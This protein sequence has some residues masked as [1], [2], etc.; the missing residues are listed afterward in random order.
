MLLHLDITSDA[1]EDFAQASDLFLDILAVVL[2][3]L[4]AVV[5][6]G[7]LAGLACGEPNLISWDIL[8]DFPCGYISCDNYVAANGIR[9]LANPVRGDRAVEAGESG[10]VGIGLLELLANYTAF[11]E[12]KQALD[13]GISIATGECI[14]GNIG[15]SNC[16]SFTALGD[17]V[18]TA[19]NIASMCP[20]NMIY[21]DEE[22]YLRV[23]DNIK[24][25]KIKPLKPSKKSGKTVLY[26]VLWENLP[27]NA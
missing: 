23:Q 4:I 7:L 27:E 14:L 9:I 11:E 8:R 13:I 24:C 2:F 6:A 1:A 26:S 5:A 25:K 12:I 21:I 22:S 19:S 20:A 17:T 3:G 18:H 15:S 10:S 16:N